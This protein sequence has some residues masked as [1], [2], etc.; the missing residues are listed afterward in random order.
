MLNKSGNRFSMLEIWK[1]HFFFT[2]KLT[3]LQNADVKHLL[4]TLLKLLTASL[5]DITNLYTFLIL[6]YQT[7][8]SQNQIILNNILH[9]TFR[10]GQLINQQIKTFSITSGTKNTTLLTTLIQI[11]ILLF[12][13]LLQKLN[14]C[15]HYQHFLM[16]RPVALQA[17]AM[18]CSSIQ[19]YTVSL[20][21]LL[22]SIDAFLIT[23]YL[24]SRNIAGYFLFLNALYLMATSIL[25]GLFH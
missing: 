4:L 6:N 15:K 1:T 19:A 16:V 18:K 11:G 13:P 7:N 3:L 5:I 2:N 12:S 20:Q 21:L 23:V 22:Y 25:Q 10:T 9:H 24:S 17:L 14:S 8:S